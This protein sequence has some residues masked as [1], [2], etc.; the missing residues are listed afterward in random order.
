MASLTQSNSRFAKIMLPGI[1]LQSVLIGGGFATGREIVEYGGQFGANG[2][3]SGLAILVGFSLLATLT[4]EACRQWEVYDY[5]SLLKKLIGK[6]WIAYEI[7]Y[8]ILGILIIAVMASAAGEILNNTLGFNVWV[9]IVLIILLVGFLNYMGENFIASMK[10]VGTIALFGAYTI[11]GVSVFINR[12]D[13]IAEVFSSWNTSFTP[14]PAGILLLIWTGIT[15]VGYNLA[16]YPATFFTIKNIQTKKESITAGFIAGLLMTIPWFLTYVAIMAYYPSEDVLGASVPWLKM[17]EPFGA[18]FV[19]IFGIVVG[20]TLV[21]T[22]TGI[23]HAFIGRIDAEVFQ[24]SKQ[25]LS[26]SRKALI[27]LVA[28]VAAMLLAQVGIIDL[29]A[30]GY[31]YMAYAMIVFYGLPLLVA[32]P[33]LLFKRES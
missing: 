18:T 12:S 31:S 28:L 1:I 6:G 5:K 3:I 16:V 2:W 23:I 22:A 9:G 21:E 32:A 10:T 25:Y 8:L 13:Q 4:F 30:K 7:S 20:W 29:I 26:G 11:F 14:E 19:V 17:L 33:K 27:S 24:K 15:Y